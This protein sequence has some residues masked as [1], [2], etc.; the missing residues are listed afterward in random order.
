MFEHLSHARSIFRV[1]GCTYECRQ[2]AHLR[3]VPGCDVVDAD[4]S[5]GALAEESRL[6]IARHAANMYRNHINDQ[7]QLALTLAQ[8]LLSANLVVDVD[9]DAVPSQDSSGL[10]LQRRNPGLNP[11]IDPVV[12]NLPKPQ[13]VRLSGNK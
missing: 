5:Q 4:G 3:L 2:A 8:R 9:I 6:A 11:A 7:R 10:I 12:P 13:A 1:D